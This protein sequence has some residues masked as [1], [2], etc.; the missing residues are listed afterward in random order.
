MRAEHSRGCQIACRSGRS[1]PPYLSR[2]AGLA[3]GTLTR[4]TCAEPGS[5]L[6]IHGCGAEPQFGAGLANRVVHVALLAQLERV[7]IS[8]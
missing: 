8:M 1:A 4:R 6:S 7:S 5:G 2:R 3:G